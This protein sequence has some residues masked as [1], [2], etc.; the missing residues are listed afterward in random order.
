MFGGSFNPIH[1]GHIKLVETM[2]EH[3]SLD[4]V[5]VVPTFLTPLKDSSHLASAIDRLSM[6]RLAFSDN[7]KV[8][9]SSI[10]VDRRGKSYTVD[11]L[12]ELEEAEP[13]CELYLI[14]GADSF[15][16]LPLWHQIEEIFRRSRIITISRDEIDSDELIATADEYRR[17]YNAECDIIRMP[18][19]EI[20]ST[21]VRNSV[22]DR[23]DISG[24]VPSC[25]LE[26]IKNNK[27]YGYDEYGY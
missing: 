5:Y 9:V 17:R 24:Y 26:Y 20:S 8:E 25:V 6:C 13:G 27:L 15:L 23:K 10:E 16:Q 21:I 14:V 1:N 12:N 4:K 7:D 18:V 3:F 22:R 19:S 11:T 2:T